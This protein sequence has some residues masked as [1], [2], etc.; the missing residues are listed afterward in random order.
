VRCSCWTRVPSKH[1]VTELSKIAQTLTV[2]AILW[3]V[4][5]PFKKTTYSVEVNFC[6]VASDAEQFNTFVKTTMLLCCGAV[7]VDVSKGHD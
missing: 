6:T 7:L 4:G 2:S 5:V 1:F 3:D